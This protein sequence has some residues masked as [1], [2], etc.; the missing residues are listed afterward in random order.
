VGLLVEALH[1]YGWYAAAVIVLGLVLV[2]A[3]WLIHS[4]KR[5]WKKQ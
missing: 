3:T 1:L 5:W 2:L 4:A